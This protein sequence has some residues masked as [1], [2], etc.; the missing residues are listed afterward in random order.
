[1]AAKHYARFPADSRLRKSSSVLPSA[2]RLREATRML[3]ALDHLLEFRYRD[4]IR[5]TVARSYLDLAMASRLKNKRTDTAMQLLTCLRYGGWRLQGSRR[6]LLSLAAYALT[7][8]W[9]KVFSRS[10]PTGRR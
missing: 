7:G 9:Y 10:K 4:R 8:T 2:T 6:T 3:T 1:M 5:A